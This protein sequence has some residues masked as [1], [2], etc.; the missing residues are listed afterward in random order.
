MHG[1]VL[2][3]ALNLAL[4]LK[5]FSSLFIYGCVGLHCCA[6]AFL[7]AKS[8]GY[9]LGQDAQASL[10]SGFLL[11]SVGVQALEA[12]VTGSRAQAQ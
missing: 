9:S 12:A 3:T 5:K 1:E 8:R 10:C 4:L 7:L 2:T 6:Q 11:Q